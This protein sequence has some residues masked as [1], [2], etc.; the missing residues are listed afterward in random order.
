MPKAWYVCDKWEDYATVVFA[1]TRGKAHEL[2]THTDCCEDS[3][4][5][6]I[7]VRRFPEMDSMYRGS[8]EMDWDNQE[9]RL[10]LVKHGWHCDTDFID[11]RECAECTAKEYCQT[12][13][14]HFYDEEEDDGER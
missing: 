2:A 13:R 9:D 1:E 11:D 8:W 10:A 6:D 14:R 12:Y 4:W 3:A 5:V 7:I